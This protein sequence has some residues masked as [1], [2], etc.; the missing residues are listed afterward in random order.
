M[1]PDVTPSPAL[2]A[3]TGGTER[4]QIMAFVTDAE[5]E[6]A[7]REGLMD[8]MPHGFEVRRGGVHTAIT[9]L[10][11]S[12]T[13]F[14]LV[15]DVSGEEQPIIALADLAEVADPDVRVLMI[16]TRQDLD[17]YRRITRGL[18]ASEYLYKPLVA[19]MVARY[20]APFIAHKGAPSGLPG[21]T[22]RGGRVITVSGVSGGVGATTLAVNL[23]WHF[24]VE[25]RRHTV[26][27][28]PDM[29]NGTAA[30][31][32]DAKISPGLQPIACSFWPASRARPSQ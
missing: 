25:A 6:T 10:Q 13:P 4:S 12:P 21:E 2:E 28:D 29:Y 1:P 7:L 5:T 30:L 26:L 20:F 9:Y 16:G 18:G 15:V 22:A 14:I 17:F 27:L 3:N 8:T 23:A 24:A 31:L 19:E 32:L 11:N